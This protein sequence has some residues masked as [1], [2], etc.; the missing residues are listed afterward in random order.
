MEPACEHG[1]CWAHTYRINRYRHGY[2]GVQIP[3]MGHS[4]SACS[5]KMGYALKQLRHHGQWRT[6]MRGPPLPG[7]VRRGAVKVRSSGAP[8]WWVVRQRS[9][10]FRRLDAV[11]SSFSCRMAAGVAGS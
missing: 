10:E 2:R 9:C 7:D 3:C 8:E 6:V 5:N 4:P 1:G 11:A